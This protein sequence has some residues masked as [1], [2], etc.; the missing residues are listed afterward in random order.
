ME[1]FYA[2][3]VVKSPKLNTKKIMEQQD[4][5]VDFADRVSIVGWVINITETY[6]EDGFHVT[7][8]YK[9]PYKLEI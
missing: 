4:N 6:N 7:V 2:S 5:A 3:Y 9:A 8:W 1:T